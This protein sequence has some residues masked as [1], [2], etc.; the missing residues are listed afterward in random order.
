ML[1]LHKKRDAKAASKKVATKE[2]TPSD[3]SSNSGQ[4]PKKRGRKKEPN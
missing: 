4:H 2:E 3:M 1:D